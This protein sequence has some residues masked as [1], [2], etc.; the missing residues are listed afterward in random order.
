VRWRYSLYDRNDVKTRIEEPGGWEEFSLKIKR[1]EERHGTFRELQETTFRFYGEAMDLLKQEKE[2]YGIRGIYTL[3]IEGKCGDVWEEEYRGRISFDSYK[4]ICGDYCYVS[5]GVDQVGPL[6]D[7]I[8]RFDQKVDLTNS[9]AF[10]GTTALTDYPNLSREIILPSKAILL[11]SAA[12]NQSANQYTISDDSGWFPVSPTGSMQGGTNV[13]FQTIDVNSIKTFQADPIID[14]FNKSNLNEYI[15]ELI[16]NDPDKELNCVQTTFQIEFRVKGVYRN[17][18]NGSGNHTLTLSIKKGLTDFYTATM[19]QGWTLYTSSSILIVNQ[20]FDITYT[21]TVTLNPGE[22]LFLATFLTYFK[23]TNF[24]E[25]V[26][27]QFDPETYFKASVISKCDPT[28]AKVSMVNEVTSRVIESITNNQLQLTSDYYGRTDSLPFAS[29][30]DGCGSLRA[31]STGLDIRRAKLA[32]GS[33]PKMFLSMKDIFESLNAIDNIGIG[34]EGNDKV[35]IENWKYFYQDDV[36]FTCRD[37]ETL[38]NQVKEKDHYSV[39]KTGYEKWEAED[40]NGLDEFLTK[41]EFRTALSEVQNTLEKVC[42]FIASGYAWEVTRRKTN[43]TKDWRF[44]NDTFIVCV[45]RKVKTPVFFL[46]TG[47]GIDISIDGLNISVGDS[48]RF[49]DTVSNNATFTVTEVNLS[50]GHTL[51]GVAEAMTA[52]TAPNAHFENLTDPF[53]VEHKNILSAAN[54][55]DPDSVYNFRIS[56]ERNAMRWFDRVANCYRNITNAD[57]LIFS[58]GDGNYKAEGELLDTLCRLESGVISESDDIDLTKFNDPDDGTPITRPERVVFKYPVSFSDYNLIKANPYG[59]IE[60]HTK[61]EKGFGW[62]D[63]ITYKPNE[64][65]ANFSLIPKVNP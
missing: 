12:S 44:D 51:I 45:A 3:V 55:L 34:A 24:T 35:R 10:D 62:I 58:S 4:F 2:T 53:H 40:F 30:A 42:K 7:F 56:P 39:F 31:L 21:G 64:G 43:D 59:L 49:T 9:V 15:P 41:R 54:I 25:S 23:A 8:N 65:L 38:E 27:I 13:P 61:C 17:L 57:K 11:R 48:I 20:A 50:G 36:I 46:G 63:E 26:K 47:S 18:T 32:D 14:Y 52:E 22:K 37:I 19:I 28:K 33:D 1:H 6:V 16:Y 5:V 60:Y 29:V